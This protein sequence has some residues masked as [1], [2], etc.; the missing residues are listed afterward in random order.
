[1]P[2][3]NGEK[4]GLESTARQI[5][6]DIVDMIYHARSGHLGGSLSI[7]EILAALYYRILSVD[8]AKPHWES[9]DR[10]ILSKGH[11]APALY[12]TLANRGFFEEELLKTSFRTC[13]GLL[14]GHP[15]MQ[16]TPGVDATSGSLG[17]GLSIGCGMALGASILKETF[18]TYVLVGDGE[19]DDSGNQVARTPC[20]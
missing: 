16:K 5:R 14:Q 6:R 1:M 4:P 8:P 13:G 7:V 11:A 17:I 20:G 3:E 2:N 12:A 18:R 9:R 15:D 10:F 19:G